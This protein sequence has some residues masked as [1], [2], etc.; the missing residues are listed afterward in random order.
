MSALRVLSLGAGVQSTTLAL[1]AARG[2]IEPP[3]CAVFADTGWEPAAVYTH[4]AK[5]EQA[6]PFP[7]HHVSRGNLR[8][9]I[10]QAAVGEAAGRGR[11]M[12]PYFIRNADGSKGILH[13]QCTRDYKVQPIKA[14]LRPHK[15]QGIEQWLGISTDEAHRMRMSEDKWIELRYP[16]VER[17]MSRSDCI[18]WLARAGWVAP[19]SSCIGCPY[20]SNE[21]WQ[22]LTVDEMAD[23]VGL[24][25]A[26]QAGR[27]HM[28]IDG[29]PFL[30]A[31]LRP[32]DEVDFSTWAERGQRDLFGE[33]CSG[34]C[35]V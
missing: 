15:A 6:L 25:R 2:E 14:W 19:K 16:L 26:I 1:M 32:L 29:T 7:V 5:L 28:G 31:S 24:D 4:L 9:D 33:D 13:R 17:E 12:P 23:A 35:G 22:T 21:Q 10:M 18:A 34:T 8:D 27:E 30:H 20:H 11:P 3:D